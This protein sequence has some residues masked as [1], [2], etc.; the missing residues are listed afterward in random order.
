R[1][2]RET[3]TLTRRAS[4]DVAQFL[5]RPH[6]ARPD[7]E[8]DGELAANV[9]L[10]PLFFCGPPPSADRRKTGYPLKSRPGLAS[11]QIHHPVEPDG[12]FSQ[13]P[14]IFDQIPHGD[15]KLRNIKKRKRRRS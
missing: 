13:M 15:H 8:D 2:R 1:E 10:P 6:P 14:R 12:V 5:K 3:P 7:G 4:F 9:T 11:H